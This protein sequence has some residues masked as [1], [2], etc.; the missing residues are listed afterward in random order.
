MRFICDIDFRMLQVR[1]N[2]IS[3]RKSSGGSAHLRTLRE[4]C[5]RLHKLFMLRDISLRRE[6]CGQNFKDL[7]QVRKDQTPINLVT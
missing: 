4:H 1:K 6:T 7:S 5:Q 2:E 3:L